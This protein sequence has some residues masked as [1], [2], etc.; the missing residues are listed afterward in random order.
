MK[1]KSIIVIAFL[2]LATLISACNTSRHHYPSKKKKK[3]RNCD[4]S[5]FS[6][7][8]KNESFQKAT[9]N[10]SDADAADLS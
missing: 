5:E 3:K 10:I 2:M 7:L 4:C 9:L 1:L 8:Q 6:F